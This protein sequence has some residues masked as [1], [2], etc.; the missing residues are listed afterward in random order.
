MA[1]QYGGVRAMTTATDLVTLATS[2]P[3]PQSSTVPGA[4]LRYASS[5]SSP[6]TFATRTRGRPTL[7]PPPCFCDGAKGSELTRSCAFGRS[8]SPPTLKTSP[9]KCRRP[10]SSN[11]SPAFGCYSTGW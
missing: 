2:I 4:K 5:N 1:K 3:L 11:I 10:R 7:M 8:T 6:S 9:T